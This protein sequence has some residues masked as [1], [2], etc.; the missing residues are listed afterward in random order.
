MSGDD[1]ARRLGLG[2]GGAAA[3][4]APPPAE[5]LAEAIPGLRVLELAGRGGMGVVYRAEQIRLGRAVAVKVLPPGATAEPLARERFEREARVLA[6]LEHPGVLRVFDFGTLADGTSYLV[7]EWAEGGDL[8][9]RLAKGRVARVE[10][11]RWV[12]QIAAALDAAHARGVVHRDLKPGNVLLRADGS[13][14][15]GDF[16]LARA[17][18]A[19]FTTALTLSWVVYGTF[20]YMAPEQADGA[21]AVT[22]AADIYALGVMT[23][24]ML[25]GRVPRG[26]FEPSSKTAGV[27]RAVDAVI[28][29]ALTADPAARPKSAGDFALALAVALGARNN[30]AA[31]VFAAAALAAVSAGAAVWAGRPAGAGE[32]RRD[33]AAEAA[34]ATRA[35]RELDAAAPAAEGAAEDRNLLAGFNPG[36]AARRGGWA[37]RGGELASDGQA[38][39]IALGA[40]LSPDFH[41][42]VEVE[43][44]RQAGRHSAGVILPTAAGTGVFELDAWEAGLGGWQM[45]DGRDLRQNGTAFPAVLRN[46]ERQRLRLVVEGTR[47]SAEWNGLRR[48]PVELAGRSFSIPWLWEAEGRGGLGLCAWQSPTVFHRVAL[49]ERKAE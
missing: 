35:E 33:V 48:G 42:E 12:E 30:T 18:G 45:I 20:D 29:K 44:T 5:A 14:A 23:Y 36:Q 49:R 3:G 46:G 19:G 11:L 38:C 10:A 25:A 13:L 26:V 17:E 4:W 2:L 8:A 16:G 40:E 9:A 28:A 21:G 6:G 31:W 32:E 22:K 47:V 43:F 39:W 37:M 41:Y 27:P 24:Q 7:M 15:L 34:A 1:T